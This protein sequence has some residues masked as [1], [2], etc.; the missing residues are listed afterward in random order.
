MLG[1]CKGVYSVSVGLHSHSALQFFKCVWVGVD[2]HCMHTQS[3]LSI[4]TMLGTALLSLLD[5][6]MV[7][8]RETHLLFF[9]R[10]HHGFV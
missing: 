9:T 2:T 6:G 8:H 7:V 10:P 1:V 5:S 3:S 4:F